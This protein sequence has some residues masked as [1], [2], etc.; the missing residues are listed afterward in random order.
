MI[1]HRRCICLLLSLTF[2]TLLPVL[3]LGAPPPRVQVGNTVLRQQANGQ[4]VLAFERRNLADGFFLEA[5]EPDGSWRALP[6]P[7]A[8]QTDV[9][10]VEHQ[11]AITTVLLPSP[12]AADPNHAA[13]FTLEIRSRSC[14]LVCERPSNA[15]TPRRLLAGLLFGRV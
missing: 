7:G 14:R 15:E 1:S 9:S 13:R 3:L 5:R 11:D 2:A 6:G 8:A 12:S 10:I 4:R